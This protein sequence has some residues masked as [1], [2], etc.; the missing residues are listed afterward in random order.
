MEIVIFTGSTMRL[1]V[2]GLSLTFLALTQG[3]SISVSWINL[4]KQGCE[5]TSFTAKG[6]VLKFLHLP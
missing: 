4:Q 1:L 5:I 2:V 3:A 6:I